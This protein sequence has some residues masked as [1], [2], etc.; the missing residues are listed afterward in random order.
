MIVFT[1]NLWTVGQTGEWPFRTKTD[2][3]GRSLRNTRGAIH[4]TKIFGNF[5]PKLNG[6]VRSNWKSFEKTGP[7]FEV[8]HF[9]RSDRSEFWLNGSRPRLLSTLLPMYY[10]FREWSTCKLSLSTFN[11]KRI[12]G[13]LL[14]LEKYKSLLTVH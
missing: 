2:K 9:S 1:E 12:D 11:S 8:D 13:K 6:W 4:S 3:C 14:S 10:A 7:P 5:G